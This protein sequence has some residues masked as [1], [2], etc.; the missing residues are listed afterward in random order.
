M[1]SLIFGISKAVVQM[2]SQ[3]RKRLPHLEKELT[4]TWWRWVH[5]CSVVSDSL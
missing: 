2:N 1:T 5:T 4:V 3:N